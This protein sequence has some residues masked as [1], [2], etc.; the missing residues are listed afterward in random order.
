MSHYY[1]TQTAECIVASAAD[2][3]KSGRAI[4]G[5]RIEGRYDAV[6]AGQQPYDRAIATVPYTVELLDSLSLEART[7]VL[8]NLFETDSRYECARHFT[9]RTAYYSPI[10]LAVYVE[11]AWRDRITK[12][13]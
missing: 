11:N 4:P 10:T 12:N 8:L 3:I 1:L 5:V 13:W 6:L 7:A 9:E 2:F